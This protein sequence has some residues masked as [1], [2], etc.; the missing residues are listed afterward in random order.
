[1][2]KDRL[3][4]LVGLFVVCAIAMQVFISL[5]LDNDEYRDDIENWLLSQEQVS[6]KTGAIKSLELTKRTTVRA[7]DSDPAYSLWTS[8]GLLDTK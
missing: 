2:R 4:K 1:M 6:S 7:T 5:T 3:F 8:Q